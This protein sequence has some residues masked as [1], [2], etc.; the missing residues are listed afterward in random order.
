MDRRQVF[1]WVGI[2]LCLGVPVAWALMGSFSDTN[3]YVPNMYADN[4]YVGPIGGA[5]QTLAQYI[6]AVAPGGTG[7]NITESSYIVWESGGTYFAQNGVTGVTTSNANCVTL[8]NA[9]VTALPAEGGVIQYK[10]GNYNWGTAPTYKANVTIQGEGKSSTI[11]TLTADITAFGMIDIE[12]VEVRD[13]EVICFTTQTLP[14]INVTASTV[15]IINNNFKSI[16][17]IGPSPWAANTFPAVQLYASGT[18]GI[19]GCYFDDFYIEGVG[20]FVELSINSAAS[21]INSNRFTRFRGVGFRV[22]ID[23]VTATG[24][25][26]GSNSFCDW[27]VEAT[28]DTLKVFRLPVSAPG[29]VSTNTFEDLYVSDMPG[30]GEYFEIGTG[31]I[32]TIIKGGV[33][34]AVPG[35]LGGIGYT[36][37]GNGTIIIDANRNNLKRLYNNKLLTVSADGAGDFKNLHTALASITDASDTKRYTIRVLG[38]IT[39]TEAIVAQSYVNVIG[40]GTINLNSVGWLDTVDVFGVT[41]SLWKDLEIQRSGIVAHPCYV[42]FITYGTNDTFVLDN[43]KIKNVATGNIGCAG[44]YIANVANPTFKNCEII[45]GA[46]G[47]STHGATIVGDSHP[48]FTNCIFNGGTWGTA[49]YG[50][51]TSSNAYP[52]IISSII[53]DGLYNDASGALKIFDSQIF[54]GNVTD[55]SYISNVAEAANVWKISNCHIE[56]LDPVTQKSVVCQSA[57]VGVPIYDSTFI[58]PFTNVSGLA[59]ENSGITTILN[60]TTSK[61]VTHGLGY[62][63]TSA[64]TAWTIS[65][66]ENPTNDPGSWYISSM[67]ATAAVINVFRDPGASNLDIAWSAQ[68]VP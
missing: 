49:C 15:S 28:V 29:A 33:I 53:N 57:Y 63:P 25:T 32:G 61:I 22:G 55:A 38:K 46:G 16:S 56:A 67:N 21:W 43:V 35:F 14:V 41:N 51:Y 20:K 11:I 10:A 68:R 60:G 64:N 24:G 18:G 52:T 19:W 40:P 36:D 65:Y 45:G 31:V 9:I 48:T 17:I 26:A 34:T 47:V 59:Y 7:S 37:N 66:L 50:V 5:V 58:G 13:L 12:G 54:S 27:N 42:F 30:T 1:G 23:V 4:Y 39:E 2:L 8:Q 62:T 6:Q 44:V 3:W